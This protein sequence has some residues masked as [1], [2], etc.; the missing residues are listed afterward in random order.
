MQDGGGTDVAHTITVFHSVAQIVGSTG[1]TLNERAMQ[2]DPAY[3]QLL[4][5][6]EA[7]TLFLAQQIGQS[8]SGG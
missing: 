5:T 1:T 8:P 6:K 4:K 2:Q 3:Q 7:R